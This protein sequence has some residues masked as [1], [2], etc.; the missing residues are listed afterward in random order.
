L[1]IDNQV[2]VTTGTVKLKAV[3]PNEDNLLFPNE[4]VSAQLLIDTQR[5]VLLVSTAAI[6]QGPD[7]KFAFVVKSDQTVEMRPLTVGATNKDQTIVEKGL[8]PGEI[9][10]TD[11]TLNLQEGSK[12]QIR[13]QKSGGKGKPKAAESS[14]TSKAQ[15]AQ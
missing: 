3:F 7:S 6:Q 9:V 5:N 2:D 4:F 14:G 10:V 8:S 15:A 11:G 13:D 12:I 1:A